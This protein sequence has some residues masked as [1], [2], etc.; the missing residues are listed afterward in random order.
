MFCINNEK[1]LQEETPRE[2]I[3]LPIQTLSSEG[4]GIGSWNGLKV[5]VEGALPQEEVEVV[6]SLRKKNYAKASLQRILTPSPSRITPICPLFGSC[7]GCQIM[8]L[9][10]EKQL[11]VK[12]ERVRESLRR[13]GHLENIVV[14]ATIASPLP[15]A[16]RNKIQL[17]ILFEKGGKKIGLY[18][19][20]S[21]EIIPVEK[22]YIQCE[23]GERIYQKILPLLNL[24]S[25]K[26]LCIKNGIGSLIILV[27]DGSTPHLMQKLA[28]KIVE[29]DPQIVG[30]VENINPEGRNAIFS[31]H[32]RLLLGEPFLYEKILDKKFRLSPPSFFQV[33]LGQ[34]TNLIEYLLKE[35]PQKKYARVVDAFCG[36][37]TYSLF[38]SA[39]AHEVIG[40]EIVEHAIQD[41]IEN[42]KN[43]GIHNCTFLVGKAEEE[44]AKLG[45]T[46]AGF[47]D[48]VILNPP[49]KG[50]EE[51]LLMQLVQKPPQT[52]V[53]ISC[54]PATLARDLHFLCSNGFVVDKIQPFDM[55]PQT[56]HV[57][58]VVILLG[59]Q[60]SL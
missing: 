26:C 52:L 8:H 51:V 23:E 36:V 19:K 4:D 44:M 39:I 40:I 46:D 32:F 58:T 20:N 35:L 29:A 12:S 42:A 56:M 53:Y 18:R 6:V 14:P 57:E 15:L 22:C 55:F 59:P 50:C 28:Q 10:Y 49:R 38:L 11:E 24:P 34:I 45:F 2:I 13:I 27:T 48:L 7:G 9:A 54:D 1:S 31:P 21:H 60:S 33:N 47:T 37:G 30:V 16:Y 17:P 25:L 43:N 3:P 5:F 41:A